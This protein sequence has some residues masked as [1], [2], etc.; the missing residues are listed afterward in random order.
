VHAVLLAVVLLL[1]SAIDA[2]PE[3]LDPIEISLVAPE[4]PSP[5]HTME[6]TEALAPI[7]EAASTRVRDPR[8]TRP[9]IAEPTS[10]TNAAVDAAPDPT[11]DAPPAL[12]PGLPEESVA[13]RRQRLAILMA[14]GNVA[15][16]GF[17]IEGQ[18]SRAGAP[19]GIAPLRDRGPSGAEIGRSLSRGLRGEAMTKAYTAREHPRLRRRPDGSQVYEGPRFAA[20]IRPDGS[21]DFQDHGAVQ[22]QG[23]SASGTFDAT[24]LFMQAA[25]QDPL[26]AER[27]W[28]MRE[29]EELR[30]GLEVQHRRQEMGSAL[31]TLRGRLTRVWATTDRSTAARRRR[32]FSIWDDMAE[33]DTGREARRIVVDFVRETLPVGSDDAYTDAELT[34]LNA[35]RESRAEFAPY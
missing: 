1:A 11:V 21:V 26:A 22:G 2:T 32:I 35:S 13:A 20:I 15:R 7:Q 4:S 31:R 17:V 23:F 12:E 33:D 29:T 30:H 8:R 3:P 24:E 34:R 27:D 6:P 19:A 18:P 14:P 25:G 9:S 5:S 10:V 28:F 16:S